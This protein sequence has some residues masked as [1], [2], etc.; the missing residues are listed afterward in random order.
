[1]GNVLQCLLGILPS[2]AIHRNASHVV[3]RMLD[4]GDDQVLLAIHRVLLAAQSPLSLVEVA[5]TRPGSYV[6]EQLA[7]MS[8]DR[9]REV[10][11]RLLNGLSVL[12]S[13]PSGSRVAER[14]GLSVQSDD[15]A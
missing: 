8:P 2:L 14:F 10:H 4:F 7:I 6:V 1:M 3:Q 15:G 11:D 5:A 13:S 9:V 12:Q